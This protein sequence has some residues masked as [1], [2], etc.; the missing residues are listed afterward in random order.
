MTPAEKRKRTMAEN[1]A[2]AKVQG[3]RLRRRRLEVGVTQTEAAR[4]ADVAVQT[5]IGWEVGNRPYPARRLPA[6]A[7]AL[8]IP[9]ASLLVDDLVLTELRVSAETLEKVRREGRPAAIATAE[10]LAAG[11]AELLLAEAGRP[12]IDT[13]PYAWARPRRSREQVLAGVR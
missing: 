9:I 3:E 2:A 11:V 7:S 12:A 10:R 1:R 13:S 4:G 5:W 6:I 8:G